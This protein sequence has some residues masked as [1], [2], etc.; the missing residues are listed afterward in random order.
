M[1]DLFLPGRSVAFDSSLAFEEV[2]HR[3]QHEIAAPAWS[4]F[5][6]RTQLFVGDFAD[7]RFRMMRTVSGRNSFNPVV[8]GQLSRA[9]IGTRVDARLQLHPLVL[10]ML[11]IFTL[12]ASRIASL[13][14]PEVIEIPFAA[15]VG[16]VGV[17]LLL[18]LLFAAIANLE[19]RKTV[20][21][22]SRVFD[23]K[24]AKRS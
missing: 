10:G 15:L 16:G 13:A 1:L 4:P 24:P 20:R 8:T 22:L 5:R 23:A 17:L 12:V 9:A 11:A 19:A 2:T 14:A 3:L 7:G 21:A 18:V 6:S